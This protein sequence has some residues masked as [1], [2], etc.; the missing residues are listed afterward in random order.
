MK[1]ITLV[2]DAWYP[3]INGVSR[4]LAQ[5]T[6]HLQRRGFEV[7]LIEPSMFRTVPCP[8]YTEIPLSWNVWRI[9]KMIN[10]SSPDYLHISTEGPLGVAAKLWADRRAL[11]YTTSYH[12]NYPIYLVDYFGGGLAVGYKAMRWFHKKAAAVLVNTDSM[13]CLLTEHHFDNLVVWG[14]GV[15]TDLFT[16]QGRV[17]DLMAELPRPILLNVGRVAVEKNLPAFYT[18]TYPGSKV[19]VGDGPFLE[20]YKR[21]YPNVHFVGAKSGEE[22]AAYYRAANVFVFPSVSDT[23]GL[24]MLESIASGVPVAA[25]PVNGPKDVVIDGVTGSLDHDLNN[26]VS[27]AMGLRCDRLRE[28][29]LTKSWDACT[30]SFIDYLVPLNQTAQ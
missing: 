26:A 24:V 29:A 20:S 16:P 9:G 8:T 11:R 19:Q 22:L 2:T 27:R 5:T 4:T 13:K 23:Y 21:Q 7:T 17:P 12:T 14:R 10:K 28:W 3:Q 30:T 1:Q 6:Q 15:D 25:Y 18:M